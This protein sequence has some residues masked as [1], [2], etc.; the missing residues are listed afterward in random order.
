M[1]PF[2]RLVLKKEKYEYRKH[3]QRYRFLKYFQLPQAERPAGYVAADAVCRNLKAVFKKSDAPTQND[4]RRQAKFA[5][6]RHLAEFEMPV[7]RK[8]HEKIG[9]DKKNDRV[10]SAHN[11]PL[12]TV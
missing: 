11:E 4:D 1:I 5:E 2:K 8:R 12:K 3:D 10:K 7:P 6:P 9:N